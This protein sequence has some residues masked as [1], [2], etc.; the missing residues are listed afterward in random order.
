VT[1]ERI[2]A[3]EF[4]GVF[5]DEIPSLKQGVTLW[6]YKPWNSW[7]KPVALTE[8]TKM[9]AWDV[10]F[11]YWQ[12]SDGLYGAAVPLSGKGFR[13]TLG[14]HQNQWGSK[15]VSYADNGT[16]TRCPQ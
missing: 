14:S 11:F 12:Y 7:T 9:E 13:T 6:R 2:G 10:Q 1:E 16:Y 4:A 15:A 8:A 3:D 5:F